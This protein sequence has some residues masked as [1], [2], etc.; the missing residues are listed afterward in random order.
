MIV[1]LEKVAETIKTAAPT[2]VV[3]KAVELARP[4]LARGPI[5]ATIVKSKDWLANA[6]KRQL[7]GTTG[8]FYR[9]TLHEGEHS[10]P[11]AA[12][13]YLTSPKKTFIE[14]AKQMDPISGGF[15]AF[16]TASSLPDLQQRETRGEALG[17]LVGTGLGW[18]GTPKMPIIPGIISWTAATK[19]G[20]GIG[21]KIDE[22]RARRA[23]AKLAQ[24]EGQQWQ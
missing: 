20:G 22:F 8:I 7:A 16:T 9:S 3:T 14:S 4:N 18:V 11:G 17:G 15:L 23:A 21:R 2:V 12:W 13:K 1:F 10:L 6:L 19:I 24:T 5:M